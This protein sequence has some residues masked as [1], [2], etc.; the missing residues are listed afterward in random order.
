[1]PKPSNGKENI[2]IIYLKRICLLK[3]YFIQ[4]L[5]A[6][7]FKEISRILKSLKYSSNQ[8]MWKCTMSI[9]H[10]IWYKPKV[11]KVVPI[12]MRRFKNTRD[13]TYHI[14]YWRNWKGSVY[15]KKSFVIVVV[16]ILHW[17]LIEFLN[18]TRLWMK[19][20]FVFLKINNL[21]TIFFLCN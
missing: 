5:F 8:C 6:T 14:Q 2:M 21:K 3:M 20:N 15:K 7:Y 16:F 10:L 1:M 11:M 13:L 19:G 9:L 4:K 12:Q 17:L 18:Q